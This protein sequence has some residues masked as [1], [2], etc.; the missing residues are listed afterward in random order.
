[1]WDYELGVALAGSNFTQG[2]R[3]E[4]FSQH[5]HESV[6]WTVSPKLSG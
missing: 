3:L 2:E 1:M 5:I 6:Y 4:V